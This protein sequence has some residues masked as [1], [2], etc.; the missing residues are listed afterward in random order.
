MCLAYP[1]RLIGF[2]GEDAIVD[3]GGRHR[4]ASMLFRPTVVAGDWVLVGAGSV[5]RSI[6]AREAAELARVLDT[7]TASTGALRVPTTPGGSR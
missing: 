7:A 3:L 2:D 5:L 6:D 4:R 1:A